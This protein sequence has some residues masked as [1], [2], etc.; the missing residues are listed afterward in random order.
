MTTYITMT[1]REF[2]PTPDT[3]AGIIPGAEIAAFLTRAGIGCSCLREIPAPQIVQYDFQLDDI[4]SFSAP[5]LKKAVS[6][7]EMRYHSSVQ[8]AR[9]AV[10][11]FSLI[12]TR[13]ERTA[14]YLRD[15]M[16]RDSFADAPRTATCCGRDSTGRSVV[17]D[18]VSA[19]HILIAGTTGS[20]KSVLLNSIICSLL[21]RNTPVSMNLVMIDPKQV[22]L[23]AYEKLPHLA[24][25]IITSADTAVSAL[26]EI[27][28]EMERR[29]GVLRANGIRQ[30]SEKPGL[31]PRLMVI[32]DELADLMIVGK[33][34]AEAS[35]VRIAQLGRAAGVHLI[36]ATQRPSVAVVTGLIKAN[37]PTKIA[38][39]MA[40]AT[41]SITVLGHGG[42]EKLT[43]R[44]DAII[45]TP[46]SVIERRFQAAF[47]PDADIEAVIDWYTTEKGVKRDREVTERSCFTEPYICI[48]SSAEPAPVKTEPR[49]APVVREEA[50]PRKKHW[51]QR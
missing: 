18:M 44:G 21:C 13:Q 1:G 8:T 11:D 46:D 39:T 4:F 43:G 5:A 6:L 40:S 41:D 33:K 12:F 32:I 14:L 37:I 29:Y 24:R 27:C 49:P 9:S 47:T 50:M 30:L 25:P 34:R 3:G 45:K 23:T 17:V 35:I 28:K 26:E 36:I 16:L 31:F 2:T 38:L 51:W 42:A 19:P 22:E 7:M 15:C 10:G 20:G 48:V